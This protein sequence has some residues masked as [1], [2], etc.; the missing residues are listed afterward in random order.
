ME[1]AKYTNYQALLHRQP[2]GPTDSSPHLLQNAVRSTLLA[3]HGIILLR[4]LF[5]IVLQMSLEGMGHELLYM[6]GRCGLHALVLYLY[7]LCNLAVLCFNLNVV[8]LQLF[9]H[10]H[11]HDD[12]LVSPAL[13][14]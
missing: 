11:L 13:L 12:C 5:E 2:D 9:N 4:P 14:P 6:L 8:R 7:L 3:V 10:L 1:K